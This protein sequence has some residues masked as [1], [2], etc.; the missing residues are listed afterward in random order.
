MCLSLFFVA[1]VCRE[2][3]DEQV[4]GFSHCLYQKFSS[5]EEADS[6]VARGRINDEQPG[7]NSYASPQKKPL[8]SPSLI[9]SPP[10]SSTS[11]TSAAFDTGDYISDDVLASFNSPFLASSASAS[12]TSM[13]SSLPFPSLASASISLPPCCCCACPASLALKE[14]VESLTA[15]VAS[16]ERIISAM[17]RKI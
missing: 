1:A 5:R 12:T 6:F 9:S 11:C 7:E 15:H 14:K 2:D 17:H 3:C 10:S 4:A 8:P 13:T 16:V